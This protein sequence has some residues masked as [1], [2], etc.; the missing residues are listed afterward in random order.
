M[1]DGERLCS[2]TAQTVPLSLLA[3]LGTD[4]TVVFLFAEVEVEIVLGGVLGWL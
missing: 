1:A 4:S 2:Q 3:I